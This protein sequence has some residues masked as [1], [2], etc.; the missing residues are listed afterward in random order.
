[1]KTDREKKVEWL[2]NYC[3]K[4]VK[5]KNVVRRNVLLG[6]IKDLQVKKKIS[7]KQLEFISK[8][9]INEYKGRFNSN[10][11]RKRI[12]EVF[13]D[14]TIQPQSSFGT[15]EKFFKEEE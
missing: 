14:L 6:M 1:M 11:V 4:L 5:Q 13:L 2:I 3:M 15:L 10:I 9:L 12:D 8:F 7:S